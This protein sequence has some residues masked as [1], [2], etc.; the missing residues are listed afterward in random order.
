LAKKSP[1][2]GLYDIVPEKRVTNAV[3]AANP[4]T[5]LRSCNGCELDIAK[6]AQVRSAF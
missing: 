5:Y 1:R 4:G 3:A 2:H 6:S